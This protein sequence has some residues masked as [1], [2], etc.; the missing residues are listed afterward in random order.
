MKNEPAKIGPLRSITLEAVLP[1]STGHIP[2]N[3]A[4]HHMGAV[5]SMTGEY[6][7][8]V[9]C[10]DFSQRSVT[11]LLE[12]GATATDVTAFVKVVESC[13]RAGVDYVLFDSDALVADDLP[14]FDW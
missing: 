1:L 10:R 7:W 4:K 13:Q 6:G 9:C 3:I 8:L 14:T 5:S 12:S 2:E 11:R